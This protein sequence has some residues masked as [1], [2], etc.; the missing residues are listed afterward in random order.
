MPEIY[1]CMPHLSHHILPVVPCDELLVSGPSDQG[2]GGRREGGERIWCVLSYVQDQGKADIGTQVHTCHLGYC[3][4][5]SNCSLRVAVGSRQDQLAP[6]KTSK[7][8]A[9]KTPKHMN[10]PDALASGR[11]APNLLQ[12]CLFFFPAIL[13]ILAYFSCLGCQFFSFSASRINILRIQSHSSMA[14]TRAFSCPI[15]PLCLL[16]PPQVYSIVPIQYMITHTPT[17]EIRVSF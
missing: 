8:T 12:R 5:V 11:H 1:A 17:Q 14:A 2:P 4:L 15:V 9:N 7:D 6:D 10:V 16:Q 13:P 3:D